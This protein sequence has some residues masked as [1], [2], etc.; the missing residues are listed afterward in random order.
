MQEKLLILLEFLNETAQMTNEYDFNRLSKVYLDKLSVSSEDVIY[1]LWDHIID[2]VRENLFLKA[3]GTDADRIRKLAALTDEEKVTLAE[4]EIVINENR[5]GYH[6]Q[7][8]VNTSDG[9]IYSYE[10]LMRPKS[11]M[12]L[13]PFHVL[14]YAELTDRL[15]D[16]E[17]ATFLNI[18]DSIE[19][20][21]KAFHGR[22]VFI[23]SIPKTKLDN[24]DFR[25]VGELLMKHSDTV[26]VE[27]TENAEFDEG[28]LNSLQERYRNLD[29]EIALDDYGTGYSNVQN[30][31]RY[32][33]NYVK[34]DRSLLTEIQNNPKK[35]H[36]VREIIEFCHDNNILALAEGVETSE[37]LH[38]VILLGADLIQG[39]YT[40]RPSAEIIEAIPYNIRQEITLY[41]QERQDG[42]DQHVYAAGSAERVLL[43]RLV[44]DGYECILVGKDG[45][46][47]GEVAIIGSPSID[48][49]IHI[50]V[51][52]NYKGRIILENASLANVKNRPCIDLSENSD[53]TLVIC[54]ENKLN[55]SG[56]R[57][58]ESA[59]LTVKGDGKLDIKIEAVE[60]F[61]I[62]NDIR[63]RHGDLIFEQSGMI[64]I[65][66]RGKTGI[67]IGSGLGGN[68]TVGQGKIVLNLSGNTGVGIGA[69]NSGS[70]LDIYTC[71]IDADISLMNGVA[72]GSMTDSSDVCIRRSSVKLNIRGKE[73][74]A[75]GTI[76]GEN[77]K[78]DISDTILT[79]NISGY[80]CTGIGSL[81]KSTDLK[82]ENGA[83]RAMVSGE[84]ALSFGGLSGDV[85]AAFINADS[86]VDL[87]SKENTQKF[88]SAYKIDTIGGRT[89]VFYN[90]HKVE[91]KISE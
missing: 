82:V 18:L 32:N 60:Y 4:V 71:A 84:T 72:I 8:I 88:M 51:A 63:S 65:G 33:P 31:L 78:A 91:L 53:V 17:R 26:V 24:D 73:L 89:K 87:R 61:A 67:C 58:P 43:D 5:F 30:L 54:G 19:N 28:E 9:S 79:V 6:F 20:D 45:A 12:K 49:D 74:A 25:R 80:R 81:E 38:T 34:I 3:N 10:A 15:N 37:E 69:L 59:K 68:I 2:I 86:M 27:L 40:A 55:K 29:I 1:K 16:I 13:S 41:H 70:K 39:Y 47:N 64:D 56:I 42:R 50:E 23:N 21:K 44:K 14:K 62:G 76:S 35:R 83:F 57:V 7:P 48:T 85:K 66:V 90:G 36:F 77:A 75:I 46:E 11:D 52:Q 22:K